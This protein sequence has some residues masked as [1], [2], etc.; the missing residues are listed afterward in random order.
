L[1]KGL[2]GYGARLRGW[3]EHA[4]ARDFSH[5]RCGGERRDKKAEGEGENQPD[6]A[7][8]HGSLLNSWMCEGILRATG[9]GRK[10][11]FAD[12]RVHIRGE[13]ARLDH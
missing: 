8:I 10:S 13:G 2:E 6:G 11:N 4:D 12:G 5:W 1:T 3:G 9:R 7:A